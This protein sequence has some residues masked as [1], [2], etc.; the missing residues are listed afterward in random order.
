V[1][2]ETYPLISAYPSTAQK[3]NVSINQ[4]IQKETDVEEDKI[5]PLFNV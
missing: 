3:A 4:K 5:P 2:F 1:Q